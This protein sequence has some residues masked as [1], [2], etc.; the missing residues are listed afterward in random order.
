[1][2][3]KILAAF[4]TGAFRWNPEGMSYAFYDTDGGNRL[5]LFF[6]EDWAGDLVPAG[7]PIVVNKELSYADFS[8]IKSNS[9]FED[10]LQVD[11]SASLYRDQIIASTSE[12][13][14][15]ESYVS[16]TFHY[17]TDGILRI[18]YWKNPLP[19]GWHITVASISYYPTYQNPL[20]IACNIPD[21]REYRIDERDLPYGENG[22]PFDPTAPVLSRQDIPIEVFQRM[23][24]ELTYGKKLES[25]ELTADAAFVQ[26]YTD[27]LSSK[28]PL[29]RMELDFKET[30]DYMRFYLMP[31]LLLEKM[32]TGDLRNQ[33]PVYKEDVLLN[34]KELSI[35]LDYSIHE[36]VPV[37]GY[38]A[39]S[40]WPTEA[41]RSMDGRIYT[42]HDTNTGYRLFLYMDVEYSDPDIIPLSQY[43]ILIREKMF[44][45]Q[46][47]GLKE[48]DP[49]EK[50]A[51]IDP[52]V[53]FY[54]RTFRE[55]WD[56]RT[57]E[58]FRL[59]EEMGFPCT[60]MHYLADGLLKIEY[61]MQE[62]WT[63]TISEI[64]FSED[65]SVTNGWGDTVSYKLDN[66]DL[67]WYEGN[68]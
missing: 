2:T 60:T 15:E 32:G 29:D 6:E 28:E 38:A 20:V 63:L 26:K 34:A 23:R 53:A 3:D 37:W 67:P 46:F 16:S 31:M 58:D 41:I 68:K 48:G 14:T 64:T 24:F 22:T 47:A 30:G 4:P 10:V 35:G 40:R 65:Y 61:K 39:L 52:Q 11:P 66:R 17:L 19:D 13:C 54:L 45:K 5:Y 51:D 25:G 12:N 27:A 57:L 21:E 33:I 59:N 62:D 18:G 8:E 36:S 9:T 7:F 55:K 56:H 49:I 1:M 43:P 50:V 42:I 44:L